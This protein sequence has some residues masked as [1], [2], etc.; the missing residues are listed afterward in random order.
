MRRIILVALGAVFLIGAPTG[1]GT[2]EAA[3]SIRIRARIAGDSKAPSCWTERYACG[4]YP[5][6]GVMYCTRTVCE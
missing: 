2:V 4:S 1:L 5:G 3:K 6:G